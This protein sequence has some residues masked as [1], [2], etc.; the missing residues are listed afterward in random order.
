MYICYLN[1]VCHFRILCFAKK[2]VNPLFGIFSFPPL[3][4]LTPARFP[5]GRPGGTPFPIL[6]KLGIFVQGGSGSLEGYPQLNI[7]GNQKKQIRNYFGSSNYRKMRH[8]SNTA[9]LSQ[10]KDV[11]LSFSRESAAAECESQDDAGLRDFEVSKLGYDRFEDAMGHCIRG[12][13]RSSPFDWTNFVR[14]A[15]DVVKEGMTLVS[16]APSGHR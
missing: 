14:E 13:R 15:R 2:G 8:S 11:R 9:F 10:S 3:P 12:A 1:G 4:S 5:P 7:G 16:E 6:C